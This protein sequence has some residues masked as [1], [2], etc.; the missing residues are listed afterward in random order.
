M[1]ISNKRR[2]RVRHNAAVILLLMGAAACTQDQPAA[3][4][5]VDESVAVDTSGIPQVVSSV[6]LEAL[7]FDT[8][9]LRQM[10]DELF[11]LNSTLVGL[12][13]LKR[14]YDA[15][16]NQEEKRRLN[17][18]AMPYHIAADR[19]QRAI[20]LSLKPP[21]DSI[22]DAYVEERKRMVGIQDWHLDHREDR[23]SGEVPGLVQPP[24]RSH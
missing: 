4:H 16:S 13:G 2:S 10:Q 23:P 14:S 18:A 17:V 6:D 22:F 9:T 12:A 19:Y 7:G 15:S 1:I 24:T 5:S 8:A 21:L 11:P 20:L 3:R